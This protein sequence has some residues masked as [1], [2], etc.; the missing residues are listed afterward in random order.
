MKKKNKGLP[1]SCSGAVK[2]NAK[3]CIVSL[4]IVPLDKLSDGAQFYLS[5]RPTAAIYELNRLD[6]NRREATYTSIKSDR[7]FVSNWKKRVLVKSL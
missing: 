7:T 2:E 5:A 1:K 3:A 4:D 6:K